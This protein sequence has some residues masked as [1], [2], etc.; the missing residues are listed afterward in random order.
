V[1]LIHSRKIVELLDEFVLKCFLFARI[2]W[3]F[4]YAKGQTRALKKKNA[5]FRAL[6]QAGRVRGTYFQWPALAGGPNGEGSSYLTH[7]YSFKAM[8]DLLSYNAHVN[9]RGGRF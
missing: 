2:T 1:D 5:G 7:K 9:G 3:I 4:A 8:I 6:A